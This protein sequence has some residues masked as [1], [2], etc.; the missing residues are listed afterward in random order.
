MRIQWTR[1]LLP[2]PRPR[3]RANSVQYTATPNCTGAPFECCPRAALALRERGS[4]IVPTMVHRPNR[5]HLAG[6]HAL[7]LQKHNTTTI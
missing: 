4:S 1:G 5:T 3:F 7:G 6:P 2:L